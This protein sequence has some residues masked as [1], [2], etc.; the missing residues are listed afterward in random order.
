MDTANAYGFGK[1]EEIV[2][3]WLARYCYLNKT[4]LIVNAY[5]YEIHRVKPI[6]STTAI[7]EKD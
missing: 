4:G 6:M 5:H 1:S 3:N 7:L 2:G